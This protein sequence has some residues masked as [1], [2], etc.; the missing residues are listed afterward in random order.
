M[1]TLDER[2]SDLFAAAR[3]LLRNGETTKAA[4]AI[5]MAVDLKLGHPGLVIHVDTSISAAKAAITAK[6]AG[7]GGGRASENTG[8][9]SPAHGFTQPNEPE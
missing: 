8:N 5:C 9:A 3:E 6:A 7:C 1:Q 4:E 2:V